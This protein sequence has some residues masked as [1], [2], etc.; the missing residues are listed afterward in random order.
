MGEKIFLV[1]KEDI[2]KVSTHGRVETLHISKS[3]IPC[4]WEEGGGF[5]NTGRAQIICDGH[6]RKKKAIYIRKRGPLACEEH[7][8]IPIRSGDIVIRAD[9]HR[10]DFAI[11]IYKIQESQTD[12][13]VFE[14][15]KINEFDQGEWDKPLPDY[16]ADAVDAAKRKA[17]TYH[18][19]DPFF[20]KE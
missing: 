3:G 10:G 6:G 15:I 5:T 17:L 9:H 13:V 2:D 18:C 7:A 11:E 16:F 1:K 20:I 4:L 8:L 12:F 19:R 14:L